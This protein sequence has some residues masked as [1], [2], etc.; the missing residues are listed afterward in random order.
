MPTMTNCILIECVVGVGL[1]VVID[2]SYINSIP[3]KIPASRT[4]IGWPLS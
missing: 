2:Y 3:G 1:A 4:R